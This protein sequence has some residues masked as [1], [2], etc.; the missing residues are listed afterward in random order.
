MNRQFSIDIASYSYLIV[1]F[2]EFYV[3]PV[4]N[5]QG[6]SKI[7]LKYKLVAYNTLYVLIDHSG[8]IYITFS[9]RECQH[10]PGYLFGVTVASLYLI[11]FGFLLSCVDVNF[12]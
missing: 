5:V 6:Y 9:V 8:V 1:W 11:S 12:N 3:S 4:I 7:T 2:S 10:F